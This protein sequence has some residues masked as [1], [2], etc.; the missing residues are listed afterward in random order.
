MFGKLTGD[1]Y[2]NT[3]NTFLKRMARKLTN[4]NG[5]ATT[6]QDYILVS[7]YAVRSLLFVEAE[8]EP[9]TFQGHDTHIIRVER[10]LEKGKNLDLEKRFMATMIDVDNFMRGNPHPNMYIK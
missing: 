3:E 6:D 8:V 1:E 9:L 5:L 10:Y 7:Q 4:S 2:T